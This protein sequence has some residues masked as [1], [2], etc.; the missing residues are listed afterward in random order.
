MKKIIIAYIPVLH[1]GYRKFFEQHTDVAALYVFGDSLIKKHDYLA[2]EIRQI[3]PDLIKRAI[4]SWSVFKKV[5]I[6]EEKDLDSLD[7]E[8]IVMPD[9]DV[10]KSLAEENFKNKKINFDTIFLRWDKHNSMAE[11][12]VEADQKIS[13]EKFDKE[14]IQK[15][16]IEAEKSSDWWRRIGAAIVKNNELIL[17]A[18]NEHLPSPHSPYAEGDP[19]NNFHKGIGI[20][21]ST[22]IHAEAR[23]IA[24]A[25]KKGI[26]LEG[27]SMYVSTFPCPPCAKQIAF[28]GIKKLY[29]TGGYSILDQ[30]RILRSQG[31]EIIFVEP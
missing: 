17:V 24:E 16:K 7:T 30:E 2:K 9:E 8:E 20:E 15:L 21:Y 19:R 18:H 26:A 23:L 1:E 25:A 13:R 11:K 22:S 31:V 6:L 5:E 12:P 28:S 27:L 10:C 29:Y 3:D 14:V 4:E